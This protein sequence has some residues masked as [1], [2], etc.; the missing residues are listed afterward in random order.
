MTA[1][2]IRSSLVPAIL[3]NGSL[4]QSVASSTAIG[5]LVVFFI[6]AQGADNTTLTLTTQ[7]GFFEWTNFGHNDGTTDGRYA[8]VVKKVT[9]GG[10]QSYTPSIAANATASQISMGHIVLQAG[11]YQSNLD[12]ALPVMGAAVTATTNGAP[13]PPVLASA[14]TGDFLFL[15]VGCWHV[16]TAG[17]SQGTAMANYVIEIQNANASHV[18][19]LAVARRAVTGASA[20][21]E[22]PATYTDNV[23]PNGTVAHT[24]AISGYV[25]RTATASADAAVQVTNAATASASAVVQATSAV[26]ASLDAY[27]DT[28]GVS[29]TITA[30][31]EAAVRDT[32]SATASISAVVRAS[33]TATASV[34]S[35]VRTAVSV[36]AS[37]DATVRTARSVSASIDSAV[38]STRTATAS[39]A[40][41]VRTAIAVTAACSAAVRAP[42][43]VTASLDAFVSDPA[44]TLITASVSAVV[45]GTA[46]VGAGADAVVRVA[47]SATATADAAV[48]SARTATVA[49]DA[50]VTAAVDTAITASLDATVRATRTAA[51]SLDAYVD[52]LASPPIA[53]A[54]VDDVRVRWHRDHVAAIFLEDDDV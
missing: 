14:V 36:T 15:A 1:P 20:L 29:P 41:V 45:R 18:T 44:G 7:S 35:V 8:V 2:V 40:A 32:R 31:L 5:D 53:A 23:T 42:V 6:W 22:N 39:I 27:V 12:S 11:T 21:A 24:I 17:A 52:G 26:T 25:T 38:R 16:T 4:T 9:V 13:D 37:A 33:S 43:A 30:S 19:H 3:T 54:F 49:L 48:R 46:T 50:H 51:A 47:R 10:A 34:S 28:G